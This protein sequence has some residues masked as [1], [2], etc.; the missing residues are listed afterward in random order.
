MAADGLL[1]EF[2]SRLSTRTQVPINATIVF[3]LMS[4]VFALIMDLHILV[5]FLSVGTLL[6]FTIVSASTIIL[7]YQPTMEFI[8]EKNYGSITPSEGT[9]A[10]SIDETPTFAEQQ[11]ALAGTLR[12]SFR[13]LTFLSPYKPGAVVVFGVVFMAI[14]TGAFASTLIHGLDQL[15]NGTWWMITLSI[16]FGLGLTISL[17]LILV[18]RQSYVNLSFQVSQCHVSFRRN[19][20]GISQRKATKILNFVLKNPF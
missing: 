6:A 9:P 20:M 12:S 18:H 16:I 13:F 5:E 11:T 10:P 4:A 14:F 7:H 17:A 19:Q 15:R 2:F 8:E 3:G 1:F